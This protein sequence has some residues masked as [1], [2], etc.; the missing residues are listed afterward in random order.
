MEEYSVSP[1]NLVVM[2][3]DQLYSYILN[4][5]FSSL[6]ELKWYIKS[7][8][9]SADVSSIVGWNWRRAWQ[10]TPVFLSG[11]SQGQR[12]LVGYSPWDHKESDTHTPLESTKPACLIFVVTICIKIEKAE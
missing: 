12:N 10:S 11:K 2:S 8:C 6:K 1:V 9:N 5:Y 4:H 7:A 3:A